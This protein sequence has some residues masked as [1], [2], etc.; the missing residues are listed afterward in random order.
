MTDPRPQNVQLGGREFEIGGY[1]PA[2]EP[3]HKGYQPTA[4]G[5]MPVTS[6]PLPFGGSNVQPAPA[7]APPT[8]SADGGSR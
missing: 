6:G 3:L 5:Q 4:N 7:P 1:Q 2:T 8:G